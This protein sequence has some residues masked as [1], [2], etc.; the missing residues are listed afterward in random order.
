MK[1]LKKDAFVFI[2][3]EGLKVPFQIRKLEHH[4]KPLIAFADV[5]TEPHAQALSSQWMFVIPEDFP[6]AKIS[7]AQ[8]VEM[9]YGFL[10]GFQVTLKAYDKI[11]TVLRVEPY[12]GQEM[13]FVRFDSEDEIM[14]P[15][16]ENLIHDLKVEQ[17]RICFDLPKGMLTL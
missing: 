12:P 1:L 2:E 14:I 9:H 6:G 4:H 8:P 7:P 3:I 15:L 5:H 17:K 13:A 10:V 11:G 16:V